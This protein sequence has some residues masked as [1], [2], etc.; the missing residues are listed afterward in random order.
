MNRNLFPPPSF[1][2]IHCFG[3]LIAG[4]E[5]SRFG[6]DKRFFTYEGESLLARAMGL[7]EK[8]TSHLAYVAP[9]P[10][11]LKHSWMHVADPFPREGP[12]QAMIG[13]LSATPPECEKALVVPVDMPFLTVLHLET[14]LRIHTHG[15]FC[16]EDHEGRVLPFPLVVDKTILPGLEAAYSTGERSLVGALRSLGEKFKTCEMAA[17]E[18]FGGDS[19]HVFLNA[20]YERDLP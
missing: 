3:L 4:G 19:E 15:A 7:L 20:N 5:S 16:L 10:L 13:G 8:L 14:M 11:E 12:L 1:S 17:I 2:S 6:S 18:P 9:T